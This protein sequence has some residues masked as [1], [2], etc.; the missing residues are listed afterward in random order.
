MVVVHGLG[1]EENR[2]LFNGYKVWMGKMKKF[3]RWV[4]VML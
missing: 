4:V 2:E 3:W 1:R